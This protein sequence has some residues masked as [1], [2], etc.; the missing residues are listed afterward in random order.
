MVWGRCLKVT[1]QTRV[2]KNFRPCRWSCAEGL[3]LACADLGERTPIGVKENFV[4]EVFKVKDNDR[5]PINE[6]KTLI[7]FSI[8]TLFTFSRLSFA[9]VLT[10]TRCGKYWRSSGPDN[11]C[12]G[13]SPPSET[14]AHVEVPPVLKNKMILSYCYVMWL[15]TN[16]I[17]L[18]DLKNIYKKTRFINSFDS[19]A[20]RHLAFYNCVP[21]FYG[22]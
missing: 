3:G 13:N 21:N 9:K 12:L 10:Q 14:A 8:F 4:R 6:W 18:N 17:F 1:L 7:I 22:I 19:S 15:R 5:E 11:F 2:L 16:S 20:I